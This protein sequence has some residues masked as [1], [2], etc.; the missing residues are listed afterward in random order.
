[1]PDAIHRLANPIGT[2][3]TLIQP[4]KPINPVSGPKDG[5]R[6]LR[7]VTILTRIYAVFHVVVVVCYV[8]FVTRIYVFHVVVVC[9]E[10]IVTRIYVFM[11]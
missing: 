11:L 10:T 6:C 8:T 9:Y 7:D 4:R 5:G 1:M 3:R 2:H